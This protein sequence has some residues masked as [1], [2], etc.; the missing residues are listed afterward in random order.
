ML[1]GS[2][3]CLLTLRAKRSS[4]VY[5]GANKGAKAHPG[6]GHQGNITPQKICRVKLPIAGSYGTQG[7]EISFEMVF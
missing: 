6:G 5:A 7:K 2:V 3:S 1:C 4:T